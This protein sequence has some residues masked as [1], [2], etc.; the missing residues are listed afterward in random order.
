MNLFIKG[1][2]LLKLEY[3]ERPVKILKGIHYLSNPF[4][5][6]NLSLILSNLRKLYHRF[7]N[8][9]KNVFKAYPDNTLTLSL[10]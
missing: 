6:I 4:L 9:I 10:R 2:Y 3:S 7:L 1:E 8:R 5:R